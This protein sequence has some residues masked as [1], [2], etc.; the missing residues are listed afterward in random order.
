M[1]SFSTLSAEALS[2]EASRFSLGRGMGKGKRK[3]LEAGQ[4]EMKVHG[5]RWEAKKKA[6]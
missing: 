3:R 4:K 5:G 6:R 1:A 2:S